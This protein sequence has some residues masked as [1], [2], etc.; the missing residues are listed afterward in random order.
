MRA[1]ELAKVA[2][3]AEALR[4]REMASRQSMRAA[5]GGVAALFGIAV[6][7]LLHVVAYHMMVPNVTPLVASLIMLAFDLI[8][9]AVCGLKALK[10]VPGPVELEAL[11]IRKQALQDVRGSV[12]F[13][14]LASE[15]VGMAFRPQ[16]TTTLVRPRGP[17]RMAGALASRLFRR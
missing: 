8:V 7:V 5:Y 11:A 1:V 2:A 4:L 6:F 17:V 16:R 12:T 13:M 3:N 9:A 15:A 10:S 14:S